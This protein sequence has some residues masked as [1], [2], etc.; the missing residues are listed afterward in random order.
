MIT[1]GSYADPLVYTGKISGSEVSG[2]VRVSNSNN[3]TC[4][5]WKMNFSPVGVGCSFSCSGTSTQSKQPLTAT[6]MTPSG[7][8]SK[9]QSQTQIES[10]PSSICA[11]GNWYYTS[12]STPP[13][14]Q[15]TAS[16]YSNGTMI[17]NSN[18]IW[19]WAVIGNTLSFIVDPPNSAVYFFSFNTTYIPSGIASLNGNYCRL[20]YL[21]F[22]IQPCV[23]TCLK[24]T[25]YA[26]GRTIANVPSDEMPKV[27][28]G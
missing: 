9:S 14:I 25:P 19:R 4:G 24:C 3:R 13:Y 5:T 26:T 8:H 23:S 10:R 15:G 28:D 17:D 22:S 16:L 18:E 27:I 6:V 11:S 7:S 1:F 2:D 12:G 20:S 21:G